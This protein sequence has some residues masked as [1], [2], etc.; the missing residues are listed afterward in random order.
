MY[1]TTSETIA[2]KVLTVFYVILPVA[3]TQVRSILAVMIERCH[4][5]EKLC[6]QERVFER[7]RQ[8]VLERSSEGRQ[9][10]LALLVALGV[11]VTVFP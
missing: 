6:N 7:I 1:A 9:G 4:I 8:Y 11:S 2:S 10:V 5:D 3:P